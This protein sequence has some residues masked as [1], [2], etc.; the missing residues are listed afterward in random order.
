MSIFLDTL[1][2]YPHYCGI[3]F[4]IETAPQE[5]SAFLKW[6]FGLERNS[7]EDVYISLSPQEVAE[8]F[9]S[10]VSLVSTLLRAEKHF[11]RDDDYE[12]QIVDAPLSSN[13]IPSHP[14]YHTD[15][16]YH[17]MGKVWHEM[18]KRNNHGVK[19]EPNCSCSTISN[20]RIDLSLQSS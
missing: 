5:G 3:G 17:L 20:L 6:R 8:I 4:E 19:T 18:A 11:V 10:R 12:L 9:T 15:I 14:L 7:L 13:T 16:T 2:H 1:H